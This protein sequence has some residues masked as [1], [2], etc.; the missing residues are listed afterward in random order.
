MDLSAATYLDYLRYL[1]ARS[2]YLDTRW[3]ETGLTLAQQQRNVA[4]AGHFARRHFLDG[5]VDGVEPPGGFFGAFAWHPGWT[6]GAVG[7]CWE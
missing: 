5:G 2:Q 1:I 4:V 3:V 6:G 7:R